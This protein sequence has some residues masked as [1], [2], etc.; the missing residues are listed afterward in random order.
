MHRELESQRWSIYLVT[1]AVFLVTL[2]VN[3]QVPLYRVYAQAAH[4]GNGLTAVVF[5][6]YVG[7]LLPMLIFLGGSSDRLGRKWIVLAGMASASLATVLVIHAPQMQVVLMARVFQGIAV[8]ITVGSATA[9]ISELSSGDAARA[10][11][12]IAV[13]SAL[14]FGGGALLTTLALLSGPTLMPWSYPVALGITVV[15]IVVVAIV[16]PALKPIGGRLIRLPYFP[17]GTASAG[18]AIALAWAV[19]GLVVAVVPGQLGEHGLSVWSGPVLFLVNCAG[20]LAQPRARRM[21]AKRAILVGLKL[22]PVGYLLL[23]GGAHIRAL[24]LVLLGAC[25]AGTG[26]YGFTYLGGLALVADSAGAQRAR[27]VAGYFLFAYTGFGVPSILIGFGADIIGL[28]AAL[29][30]FGVI[31]VGAAIYLSTTKA[32]HS[33][34]A[35]ESPTEP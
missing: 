23:I 30:L 7:G 12:V 3:L 19:S 31:V 25:V 1:F 14:G 17:P 13:A 21:P 11:K 5:A 4:Y 28:T 35:S 34:R 2:A 29:S 10:S 32:R 6:C 20:V 24:P 9:Y 26:C 18:L 15:C 33:L 27:G 22:I 8:G 16:C